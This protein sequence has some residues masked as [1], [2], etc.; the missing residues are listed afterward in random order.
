MKR[1]W[2]LWLV[3]SVVS[4]LAHAATPT[5]V[6]I[7]AEA[8][9]EHT[10]ADGRGLAWEIFRQVF[11][12]AGVQLNIQSVPYTRSIGLVQRGEADAWAGSYHNEVQQGVFYPR[13]H[14]DADQISAL[15]LR[16]QAR[17]TL[18]TLDQYRLIWVRGY[19]YQRYLPKVGE[20]REVIRRG[21]ILGMLDQHHADFYIDAVTEVDDVLS[22]AREPAR[23]YVTH[24]TKLPVY[25]G[26]ADN[27]RGRALA[28]LFDKRMT[29]LINDGSLRPIFQRWQQ[30]YPFN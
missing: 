29:V 2:G 6:Q 25:L 30:P 13:W 17:P 3:L 12:P 10:Q 4:S 22:T 1:C 26:F 11:E 8:W 23:Y 19:E 7:A 20:Y 15:G 21:G 5:S 16:T 24:L 14:Y 27:A 18:D 28:E 9:P